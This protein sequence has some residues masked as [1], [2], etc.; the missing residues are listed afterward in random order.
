LAIPQTRKNDKEYGSPGYGKG[1]GNYAQG[2]ARLLATGPF[3][4]IRIYA[5]LF[6]TKEFWAYKFL[7]RYSK[8]Q[9]INAGAEELLVKS[10][11]SWGKKGAAGGVRNVIIIIADN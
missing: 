9:A 2:A 1:T 11:E 7:S 4:Y 6:I 10:R 3:R 5:N 8:L